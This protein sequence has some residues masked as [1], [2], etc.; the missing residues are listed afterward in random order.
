MVNMLISCLVDKLNVCVPG[1]SP[2]FYGTCRNQGTE[3]DLKHYLSFYSFSVASK[4]FKVINPLASCARVLAN[5][6]M[7]RIE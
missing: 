6:Q 3:A 2:L 5:T 1:N 4:R 7:P